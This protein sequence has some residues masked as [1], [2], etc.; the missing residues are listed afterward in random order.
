MRARGCSIRVRGQVLNDAEGVLIEAAGARVEEFAAALHIKAPP[1]ALVDDVEMTATDI[2]DLPTPFKIVASAGGAARTQ[3]T[4]DAATCPAC[5]AEIA[6]DGRRAG[7]AFT[8]CTH[9]GQRFSILHAFPCD[10]AQDHQAQ[11]PRR[12]KGEFIG[13]EHGHQVAGR[14]PVFANAGM[15]A[16]HETV[17]LAE[18]FDRAGVDGVAVVT[19]VFI[20]TIQDGLERHFS[21]VADAVQKPVYLYDIPARTQKHIE[22]ATARRL[23]AH[24]NIAGIKDSGG[25]RQT[26]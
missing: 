8:N 23:A 18:A 15:P 2:A 25:A 24:G 16:T 5:L 10:R 12:G 26:L 7:Y 20:A 21:R 13:P 11:E 22:P 6:G 1:L 17:Q 14:V 4:P 3:V 9:C 19:P